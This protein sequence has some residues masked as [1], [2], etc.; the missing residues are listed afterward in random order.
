VLDGD[1]S[2]GKQVL[3]ATE[4]ATKAVDTFWSW[5]EQIQMTQGKKKP[6]ASCFRDIMKAGSEVM[7]VLP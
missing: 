6:A 2:N 3:P 5:L 4:A 1:E 7:G